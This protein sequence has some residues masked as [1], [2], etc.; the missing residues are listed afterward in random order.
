MSSFMASFLLITVIKE[1]KK[2]DKQFY[3]KVLWCRDDA[4]L[5]MKEQEIRANWGGNHWL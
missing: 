5:A 4:A 3:K 1:G 2:S